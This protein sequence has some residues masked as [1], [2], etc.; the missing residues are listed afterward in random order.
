MT[1]DTGL[2]PL[3]MPAGLRRSQ[4]ETIARQEGA[5]ADA[6]RE[7][8]RRMAGNPRLKQGEVRSP[9]AF[10]R[11]IVRAVIDDREAERLASRPA[12]GRRAPQRT[13]TPGPANAMP[14]PDRTA[15][16]MAL[17]AQRLFAGGAKSRAVRQQLRLE[18]P[19]ASSDLVSWALANGLALYHALVR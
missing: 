9:A 13:P 10:F 14:E 8:L 11:G 1:A 5:D 6:I 17:R 4:I 7:A 16:R 3:P 12:P 2:G 15:G 19:L 18:F